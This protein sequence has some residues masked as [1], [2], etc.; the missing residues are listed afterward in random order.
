[1]SIQ[2]GCARVALVNKGLPDLPDVGVRMGIVRNVE[3]ER[4]A[5]RLFEYAISLKYPSRPRQRRDRR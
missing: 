4:N 1:M 3:G 2:S 5:D